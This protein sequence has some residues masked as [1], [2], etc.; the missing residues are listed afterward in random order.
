MKSDNK[1]KMFDSDNLL[2]INQVAADENGELAFT[3]DLR[4]ICENPV[5]KLVVAAAEIYVYPT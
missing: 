1:N 5:V 3:Y 2:Y 4:E